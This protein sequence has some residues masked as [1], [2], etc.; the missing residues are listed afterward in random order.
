M[1]AI[2]MMTL[3]IVIAIGGS[4]CFYIHD[5]RKAKR[6]QEE[7]EQIDFNGHP[8][9]QIQTEC[10]QWWWNAFPQHRGLLFAVM[11]EL[12][13]ELD[14]E[15]QL[16]E[17]AMRKAMGV[18][19]GVSDFVCL[20]PSGKWHGIMLECKATG[21]QSEAQKLWQVRV[22][23]M[24]YRYEVFRSLEQFQNIIYDYLNSDTEH[25]DRD[26]SGHR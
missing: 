13:K 19:A 8:E 2:I 16:K 18:F 17:A 6:Q 9:A 14:P 22:T 5:N 3:I 11:N 1:G 20:V 26:V 15:I 12:S 7:Q 10:Y 21:R 24:G 23:A 25:Q 4:V